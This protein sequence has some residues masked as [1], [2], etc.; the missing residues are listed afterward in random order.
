[1]ND[2]TFHVCARGSRWDLTDA[3][4]IFCCYVCDTC[5][6]EKRA[7]YR[8]DVFTDAQYWADEPID[9]E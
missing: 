1:M 3:R 8:L 2:D 9:A 4:G 5:E 6:A 7:R